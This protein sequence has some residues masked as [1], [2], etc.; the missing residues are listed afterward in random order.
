MLSD[1]SGGCS[2]PL[3]TNSTSGEAGG[4]EPAGRQGG[5]RGGKLALFLT[6][7]VS[8]SPYRSVG[9]A[10]FLR[11]ADNRSLLLRVVLRHGNAGSKLIEF[12]CGVL[13]MI[14]FWLRD[15]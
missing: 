6:I 13:M 14:S 9:C 12:K 1:A 2:A 7:A 15:L 3:A 5:V 4:S 8:R 10:V 11:S